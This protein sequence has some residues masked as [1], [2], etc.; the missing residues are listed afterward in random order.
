M[1]FGENQLSPGSLGMSPLPTAPPTALQRGTVRASSGLSP[2]LALAMGSSPGFGPTRRDSGALA[3]ATPRSDSLALR[4]R[5][6]SALAS[7]RPCH[8]PV[9]SSIGTP[10]GANS[11]LRPTARPRFQ[12]LFHPPRRGPFHRSLTVLLLYGSPEVPAPWGVVPPASRPVP[13]AGR[14]SRTTPRP[15][16]ALRLRGSHPLR[17]ALPGRFG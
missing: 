9:H 4:L 14:Y 7:P 10:S 5:R 15:P 17:P 8:S 2:R 6:S 1:H 16:H 11:P 3:G 13:R 12:A